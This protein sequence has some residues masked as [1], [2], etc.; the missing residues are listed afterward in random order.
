MR[1]QPEVISEPK[2]IQINFDEFENFGFLFQQEENEKYPCWT[3]EFTV[4]HP[5]VFDDGI[6]EFG[7]L[8]ND[9]DR[10]PMILCGTEWNKLPNFLDTSP[11]L[12][13]IW[14]VSKNE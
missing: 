6:N 12:K 7:G 1:S 11:E 8:Y 4:Q 9:C 5:S 10:V 2:L 14:F 3:F 13:N